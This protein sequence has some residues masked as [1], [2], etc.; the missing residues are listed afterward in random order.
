MA[1]Q[2]YFHPFSSYCQKALIAFYEHAVPFE[3]RVLAGPE[4]PAMQELARRW[5]VKRFP[6]LVDGERTILEATCIVEYVDQRAGGDARLIPDDPQAALEVRMMDRFFDNYIS[7]PQ[8][9]IVFN[10][11]RPE[12]ARDPYGDREA[13]E[14]LESAYGWLD[15]VMADR[16][17]AAGDRFSLADCAAAPALFYADWTHPIG[18]AYPNVSAY[19]RRLLARP[20]FARAV[21]EARPYRSFFPLGAPDRD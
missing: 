1:L 15:E 4:S 9:R 2:L 5:P 21:D 13:R 12:D 14:M 8:G 18:A 10:S 11:L 7:T 3:P 17:W 16:E 6:V 20:S 19:R